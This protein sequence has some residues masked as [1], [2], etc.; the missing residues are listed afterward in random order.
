MSFELKPDESLGK[1]LRR[2]VRGQL[3][4]GLEELTGA[5]PEPRDE[6]LHEAR[7]CFKKVRAMLRL[8]RPKIG[9]KMYRGENL[10]I[11]DAARPLTEVRDAKILI[12]TL[13]SL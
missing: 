13:D 12:E 1:G 7:K 6:A 9:T 10:C 3:E 11:R 4:N 2:I 5:R 8:V